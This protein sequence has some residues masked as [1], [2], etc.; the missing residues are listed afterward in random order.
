MKGLMRDNLYAALANGRA[1]AAF[2]LLL[3]IFVV[4]MDNRIPSLVIGYM[5]LGMVGFSFNAAA[6]LRR[7]GA[8][9]WHKYKLTTPVKRAA[10]VQSGFWSLLLWLL[11]G[12][13]FAGAGV[14]L[15]VLLH[16]FP[17]DRDTDV[18]MLFVMGAAVSLFMGAIFFPLFYGGGEE[19]TEVSL[20][21]SLLGGIGLALG[22]TTLVNLLFPRPMTTPQVLLG[23]ALLLA[24]ALAAF[25]L[26]YPLSARLHRKREY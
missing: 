21:I 24:G 15:S 6:S 7:E 3:G 2:M 26:S 9:K 11:V 22:L 23:G 5:L 10:I 16:G 20:V 17:F 14:A 25:A 18:F 4:A 8:A 1:F 13:A 12:M 19:R